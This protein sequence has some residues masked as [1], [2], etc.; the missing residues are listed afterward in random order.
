MD[1]TLLHQGQEPIA[2]FG[3]ELDGSGFLDL[4]VLGQVLVEVGL[5]QFLHYVVVVVA[6]QHI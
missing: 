6:D 1:D 2:D 4:A 5:A 3:E